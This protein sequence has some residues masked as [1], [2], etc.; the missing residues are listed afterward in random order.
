MIAPVLKNTGTDV[1]QL[2][3]T[4]QNQLGAVANT[5]CHS[6]MAFEAFLVGATTC[7]T[8][9]ATDSNELW[10]RVRKAS[11]A[12]APD[13]PSSSEHR[14]SSMPANANTGSVGR[15][16]AKQDSAAL[17]CEQL[18]RRRRPLPKTGLPG[19]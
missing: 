17:R 2:Y 13:S 9:V 14:V 19:L 15:P 10:R 1:A 4:G 8:E 11:R 6:L 7:H 3:G 5:G 18:D 12:R 16:A